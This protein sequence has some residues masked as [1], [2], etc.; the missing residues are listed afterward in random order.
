[1]NMGWER[2]HKGSGVVRTC[3]VTVEGRVSNQRKE[4]IGA[5]E[6]KDHLTQDAR[7]REESGADNE[8]KKTQQ[9]TR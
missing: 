3:S 9:R 4:R 8:I 2:T 6:M 5:W 7:M 1:M